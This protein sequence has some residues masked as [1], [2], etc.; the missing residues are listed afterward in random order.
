MGVDP[1]EIVFLFGGQGSQ[2]YRMGEDLYRQNP[3]FRHWMERGD[4]LIRRIAGRS[5]IHELYEAGHRPSEPFDDLE[6]THPAIF[7][8]EYAL[9]SALIDAGIQPTSVLGVSLGEVAACAIAGVIAFDETVPA[10]GQQALELK[11]GCR[12]GGMIAIIA[13][14]RTFT[15]SPVLSRRSVLAGVLGPTHYVIAV[16]DMWMADVESHLL[17]REILYSILPLRQ[18]FH[19]NW[20]EPIPPGAEA[21][22][23]RLRFAP[24]RL[25]VFSSR[26]AG[27]VHT[28][29][30]AHLWRAALDPMHFRNAVLELESQGPFRF[31][32][33]SPSGTLANLVSANLV[34][35]A[36]SVHAIGSPF[37]RE[38]TALER[39]LVK[40][41]AA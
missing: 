38:A 29:T 8:Y 15:D 18:P 19:S 40:L 21:A 31:V 26:T 17:A 25:K 6:L 24:P 28:P 35:S 2:L 4:A 30:A 23:A 5:L 16:P 33:V 37:G 32:D 20:V 22:L 13:E 3:T 39:V 10:L 9:A 1:R 14:P 36:S 12:A 7:V 27:R 11:R 34:D 41:R